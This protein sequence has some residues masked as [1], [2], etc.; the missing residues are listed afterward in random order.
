MVTWVKSTHLSASYKCVTKSQ[1]RISF[2]KAKS[3]KKPRLLLFR[4]NQ[5]TYQTK[6]GGVNSVSVE[7]MIQNYF[8]REYHCRQ[9]FESFTRT[10]KSSVWTNVETNNSIKCGFPTTRDWLH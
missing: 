8:L 2:H 5:L 6:K 4:R 1:K 10:P 7:S 3:Q 9:K